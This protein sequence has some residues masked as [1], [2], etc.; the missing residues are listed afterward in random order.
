MVTGAFRATE[1][2][3]EE[4]LRSPGAAGRR[5]LELW[6]AVFREGQVRMAA[7]PVLASARLRLDELVSALDAAADTLAST[8]VD[9]L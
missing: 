8:E 5:A 1:G 3:P 7:A 9:A 4:I 6:M 2:V